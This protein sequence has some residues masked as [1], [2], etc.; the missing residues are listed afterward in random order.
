MVPT[1]NDVALTGPDGI[2]PAP[3]GPNNAG[4]YQLDARAA[5]LQEQALGALV[6]H[7][8][9]QQLAAAAI[10]RR[11]ASFQRTL[12]TN[13]RV[14]ALAAAVAAGTQP[15]PSAIRRSRRSSSRQN[16]LRAR[17]RAVPRRPE[18]SRRCPAIVFSLSRHRTHA[19]GRHTSHRRGSLSNVS[20]ALAR[21]AQTY[22]IAL[23]N[24]ARSGARAPIRPA[25]LTGIVGGPPPF[26][27]W[28]KLDSR[29]CAAFARPRRIS[30]TTAPTH[31]R[32]WS[33]TTSSY[34][35]ACTHSR[36]PARPRHRL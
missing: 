26:D 22:E 27:D 20:R 28:N 1:V 36:L 24:D 9:V 31:W 29:G 2:N 5:T 35:S 13:Q 15:L 10:S 4:G 11:P 34:S 25:L 12:F 3:R 19:R 32:K 16:R 21:N 17:L 6:N 18:R 8:Q 30:T 14:R 33:T 23:P 7:A